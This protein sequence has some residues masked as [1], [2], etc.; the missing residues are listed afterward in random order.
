MTTEHSLSDDSAERAVL[1]A[2]LLCDSALEG[3]LSEG[4]CHTDFAIPAHRYTFEAMCR[5]RESNVPLDIISLTGHL[6]DRSELSRVG[7]A[8]YLTTLSSSTPSILNAP[9]YARTI[10]EK[11]TLRSALR[12]L[13]DLKQKVG[14]GRHSAVGDN[15][16][17]TIHC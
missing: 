2:V 12:L 6:Q 15:Y 4:L 11:S 10:R 16:W 1:G 3:A 9:S 8:T 5:L 17:G 7:G 14:L 13:G